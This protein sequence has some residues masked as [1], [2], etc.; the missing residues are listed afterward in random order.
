MNLKT[1]ETYFLKNLFLIGF[2]FNLLIFYSLDI[3]FYNN[4]Y[5][6]LKK[7]FN[8]KTKKFIFNGNKRFNIF[9]IDYSYF[10]RINIIK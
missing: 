10:S 6:I 8:L 4:N 5:I 2:F 1:F 3:Y 7:K 9:N